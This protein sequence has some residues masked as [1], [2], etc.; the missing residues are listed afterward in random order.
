MKL[1]WRGVIGRRVL[2]RLLRPA[3]QCAPD[4]V[5]VFES[6]GRLIVTASTR[7]RTRIF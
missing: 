2:H 1:N 5:G 4:P 7:L 6:V 3:L